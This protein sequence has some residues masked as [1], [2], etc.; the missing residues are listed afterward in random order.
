MQTVTIYDPQT[1]PTGYV[2][3]EGAIESIISGIN[4]GTFVFASNDSDLS[5]ICGT[6]RNAR[7]EDGRIVADFEPMANGVGSVISQLLNTTVNLKFSISGLGHQKDGIIQ[8]YQ[9]KH[10][11]VGI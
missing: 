8:N 7:I 1:S 4:K 10:V 6:V 9:F 2:Y 3:G 11:Q 5:S